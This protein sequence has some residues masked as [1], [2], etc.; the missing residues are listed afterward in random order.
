MMNKREGE[1]SGWICEMLFENRYT[2]FTSNEID[3][4]IKLY[5]Y[6]TIYGYWLC[7]GV[8]TKHKRKMRLRC[9]TQMGFVFYM[10][11]PD[12]CLVGWCLCV[13]ARVCN[14]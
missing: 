11:H 1:A 9:C 3:N 7:I 13:C 4:D 6:S 8:P 5:I 2:L 10:I 12:T 14:K